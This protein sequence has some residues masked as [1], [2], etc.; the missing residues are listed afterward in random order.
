MPYAQPIANK[1]IP[2]YKLIWSNN[3]Q[4]L[5]KVFCTR[6][7]NR[8]GSNDELIV[9]GILSIHHSKFFKLLSPLFRIMGA[10]VP[11][12]ATDIP[13]TVKFKSEINSNKLN[14]NRTFY[15][16][17]NKPYT[18][19]SYQLFYENNIVVE[20]MKFRTGW[21]SHFIYE[22]NKVKMFHHRYVIKL[23]NWLI[24]LPLHLLMGTCYAEEEALSDTEFRM[25]LKI[26]HPLFGE[27]FGY[28]GQFKIAE[29]A[30]LEK[31]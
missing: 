15:F 27:L 26:K 16:S 9:N 18:F 21:S 10:L 14:F 2:V 23:F 25:L 11:Y 8:I 3:Y 4:D 5:P 31:S 1:L 12:T 28:H 6:Y 20:F 7:S 30:C 24:P 13:V 17:S 22:G 29:S 19:C